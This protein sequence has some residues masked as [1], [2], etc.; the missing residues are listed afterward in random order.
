MNQDL[1]EFD[2]PAL[3]EALKRA[4]GSQAAPSDLRQRIIESLSEPSTRQR[5]FWLRRS[6]MALAAALLITLGGLYAWFSREKPATVGQTMLAAL[7]ERH[8]EC[9]SS[10]QHWQPAFSKMAMPQIAQAMGAALNSPILA[11]NLKDDGWEFKGPAICPVAGQGSA[12]LI[13]THAGQQISV[14]T[15]PARSGN[16]VTN[17]GLDVQESNGHAMVGFVKDG[18]LYCMV[19][20]CPKA[21]LRKLMKEHQANVVA[22]P[23]SASG[24]VALA[25]FP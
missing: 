24:S 13:F 2:D 19:S 22:P 9:C 8:D 18:T 1:P 12:H 20:T 3:K 10:P 17:G 4:F 14:F 11:A 6:V 21:E 16:P 7:V 15:V 23:S 25:D 5:T